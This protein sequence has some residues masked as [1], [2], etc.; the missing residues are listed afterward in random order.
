L[1][2]AGHDNCRCTPVQSREEAIKVSC[3]LLNRLEELVK[4]RDSELIVLAEHGEVET[5][6]ESM[7]TESVLSCLTDPATG[8]VDLKP[9]LSELKAK[10]PAR[11]NRL[12]NPFLHM[13]AEGNEFV[14]R[15]I[16]P[17]LNGE[18]DRSLIVKRNLEL[19]PPVASPAGVAR[20][21]PYRRQTHSD[22][23]ESG[24]AF[25]WSLRVSPGG[26]A[27]SRGSAL[28]VP[29]RARNTSANLSAT[30]AYSSG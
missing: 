13:S 30:G 28:A 22:P 16:L 25:P 3:A 18:A 24:K 29:R 19:V 20:E 21:Q 26:Q 9:P 11:H 6:W 14:A 23:C 10:D 15:Q 27:A 2:L 12:Y 8:V 4:L 17:I 7:A 5:S 1:A